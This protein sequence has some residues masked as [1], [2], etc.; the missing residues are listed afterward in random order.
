MSAPLPVQAHTA[1]QSHRSSSA[2]PNLKVVSRFASC[3]PERC[4]SSF[5]KRAVG[6]QRSVEEIHN[7]VD[8]GF[9]PAISSMASLHG[10]CEHGRRRVSHVAGCKRIRSIDLEGRRELRSQIRQAVK[11]LRPQ[12]AREAG[13]KA[14][15]FLWLAIFAGAMYRGCAMFWFEAVHL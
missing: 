15:A 3:L 1:P 14:R 4:L 10:R 13:A 7:C 11:P 6:H 9:K 2:L 12:A 8:D 5:E